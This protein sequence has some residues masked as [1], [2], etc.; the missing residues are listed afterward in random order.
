M[1]RTTLVV[2]A[3]HPG[4]ARL[5]QPA[6][7]SGELQPLVQ[8]RQCPHPDRN[9][10][11]KLFSRTTQ[12]ALAA[13]QPQHRR[14]HCRK[15]PADIHPT[16]HALYNVLH[17]AALQPRSVRDLTRWLEQQTAPPDQPPTRSW[18]LQLKRR[19]QMWIQGSDRSRWLEHPWA[20]FAAMRR[21]S[22]PEL[23]RRQIRRW[24]HAGFTSEELNHAAMLPGPTPQIA[25]APSRSGVVNQQT[26]SP[27]PASAMHLL[28]LAQQQET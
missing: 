7:A 10:V 3:Q 6:L 16:I 13:I 26:I 11:S 25:A 23:I 8:S 27:G 4:V 1:A 5:R 2:A 15:P 19:Y 24:L 9:A 12:Q 21:G 28:H 22:E 14:S 18:V 17:A 20:Y